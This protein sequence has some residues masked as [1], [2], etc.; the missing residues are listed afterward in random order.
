MPKRISLVNHLNL[1]ELEQGY[2]QAKQGVESRQ[3]QIIKLLTQGKTTERTTFNLF[4]ISF[5]RITTSR[6]TMAYSG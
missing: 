1:E 6:T 5:T 2:R 3:Y 4:A